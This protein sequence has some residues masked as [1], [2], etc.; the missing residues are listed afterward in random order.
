MKLRDYQQ[1]MLEAIFREWTAHKSTMVVAATGTGKTVV[2]AAVIR[3]AQPKPAL[4]LAHREE[5]IRQAKEKIEA[6][7][8]L[9]VEIE[10]ADLWAGTS[11]FHRNPVVVSSIQTQVSG[12]PH[13]RRYMRFNPWAFGI[14][15]ID[16]CHHATSKSYREV[17]AW[18]QRNP[19]LRVLGVTATPDRAD[20]EALGQVF[21]SVA[22]EYDTLDA[23]DGGHLVGV[24]QQFVAVES[25]DYSHIRTTAGDLNEGD[26]AKVM[27]TEE[28]IQGICQPTLE[29]MWGLPPKTLSSIPV[30]QWHEY[31]SGLGRT[32]RRT[33]IFTASVEQAKM[34]AAVLSRAMDGIEWVCGATNK[35]QRRATLSRFAT[36]ETHAVF[37]CGVL[38]EGFDNPRV[39][40]IA[41][42]RPTKSRALYAQ[43]IGR[44]TRP[45]PGVVDGLATAEERRAAIAA[46][47][48]PFCR[49]LDFTG[50]SGH[51]KLVTCADILGGKV[52]PEAV[53]RAKQK[54]IKDGKPVMIMVTMSNAEAELERE[55]REKQR[56]ERERQE[57]ARRARLLAKSNY[58]LE[59]VDPFRGA[60][61]PYAK[62]NFSRDGR[63]FT[64]RQAAV[65]RNAGHDPQQL[66]YGQGKAIIGKL[67]EKP[68]EKQL[69]IIRRHGEN[70][71]GWSRKK[72][73]EWIGRLAENGWKMEAQHA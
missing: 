12:P 62:S 45:L 6:V 73:S 46:S 71:N 68:S 52:S 5:L 39:E 50:N 35:D 54:A 4:V 36:G 51:H 56:L 48:K 22:Y 1:D 64:E 59:D 7:A 40:L 15:I 19:E 2:I 29:A 34:G 8:G 32:P 37:N 9:P 33:I 61:V 63:G 21:E 25:L 14:L 58:N 10:K 31:L 69:G 20:E 13:K 38:L 11:L 43:A 42:A 57:A 55:K 72:C 3:E 16:E 28:N 65:L 17:V 26:L 30:A 49:V 60:T 53:D 27:E 24:T 23:I 44:S 67:L 47:A 18:Y 41:M 66:G 70:P